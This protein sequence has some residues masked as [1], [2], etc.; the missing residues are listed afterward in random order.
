MLCCWLLL[1]V[2]VVWLAGG[3]CGQ[4]EGTLAFVGLCKKERRRARVTAVTKLEKVKLLFF[5]LK[6]GH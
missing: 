2:V 3:F 4:M 6:S 5:R 1:V